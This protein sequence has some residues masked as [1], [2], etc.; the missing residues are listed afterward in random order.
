MTKGEGSLTADGLAGVTAG[1]T[2]LSHIDGEE[3]RLIYRGFDIHDLAAHSTYEETVY[4][5]WYDELPTRDALTAFEDRLAAARTLTD[6]QLDLLAGFPQDAR[7]MEVLRAMVAALAPLDPEP[8]DNSP[9]A[10]R[11]KGVRLVSGF[12][13]YVAAFHRLRNGE[14]VVP[15]RRDL[16][17]A[18]N[19]LYMLRG[20]EPPEEEARILDVAL[21]LHADHGFNASTFAAR[22]TA[23]TLAD[24]YSASVAALSALSGALHGGANQNAMR[25]LLTIGEVE[26]AVPYVREALGRKEKIPGFGHRVYRTMDPRAAILKEHA[27]KLGAKRGEPKWTEMQQRIEEFLMEEKGLNP[28]VDFYSATTYY[29]LGIARDLYTPIFAISRV[30]GWVA[31]VLEQYADNRL[32]RPRGEYAGPLERAYVPLAER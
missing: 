3:G 32:I 25:M 24:V 4:L 2:S 6:Q 17:H 1:R 11:R 16:S 26:E 30:A 8:D 20:E 19:F 18:A 7:P 21:I 15:P 23:S 13:L 14:A 12:P 29:N 28:N 31:H 27:R 10:T 22:V 9:D 5:L